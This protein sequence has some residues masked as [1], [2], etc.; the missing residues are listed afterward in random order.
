MG[1]S[2]ALGI[3]LITL[4]IFAIGTLPSLMCILAIAS[5]SIA[6]QSITVI[7]SWTFLIA[8]ILRVG[9][10]IQTRRARG[11]SL[12]LILS[13]LYVAISILLLNN[14]IGSVFSFSIALGVTTFTEGVIEV[15]LVF[16]LRPKSSEKWLLLLKGIAT[17]I[18]GI[19]IWSEKP[20]STFGILVLL[21]GISL[22]STG[23][24]MIVFAKAI[25]LQPETSS[26]IKPNK[27]LVTPDLHKSC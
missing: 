26:S 1:W 5:S 14:I 16:Q 23:I 11:F 8:G 19:L 9:L 6:L 15:F 20:F 2:T 22:L 25:A 3:L 7:L 24:W 10:T 21:P 4:G 17:V 18:L 27:L 13:I 12:K